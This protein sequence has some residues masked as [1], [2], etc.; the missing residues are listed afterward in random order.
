[1]ASGVRLLVTRSCEVCESQRETVETVETGGQ[2]D[3]PLC[4]APTRV[5]R[6]EMLVPLIPDNNSFAVALSRLGAAKGGRT[7][8][9]GL[10][11]A[12]RREI[13]RVAAT[14]RWRRR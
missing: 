4:Y 11:A 12:R 7:R 8:A 3:C 14:A 2:V 1:M 13:A 10:T 9:A 6:R 5:I